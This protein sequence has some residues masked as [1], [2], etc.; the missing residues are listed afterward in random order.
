MPQTTTTDRPGGRRQKAPII[1]AAVLLLLVVAGFASGVGP[2][3]GMFGMIALVAGGWAVVRG[4]AGWL[5]L[6]T[7]RAGLV[8]SVA[9][10]AAFIVGM[11]VTAT[12]TPT[13]DASATGAAAKTSSAAPRTSSAAPRTSAAPVAIKAAPAT[14]AAPTTTSAS[15]RPPA[16][17]M[18]LTCPNGGSN[19]SPVF[20]QTISATAPYTVAI[21]YGD[22]DR[23]S[24]D[25]QHLGAV[26]SHTYKV[27]GNFTVEAT[28]TDAVGQA[29]SSSC[30]YNWVKL[31][32][33]PKTS[34]GT[35]GSVS[36]GGGSSS[37]TGS[38]T[39]GG[40]SSGGDTYTN[41]DGN[42]VHVPVQAPSAPAGATARCR[43]GSW[44][45]SQ[46]HSGTCSHHGGVAQWLG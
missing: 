4:R 38:A 34:G 5:H 12:P 39:D 46:N 23:Y 42:Q 6:A 37:G 13:N 45:F 29:V 44:S 27:S 2:G 22:G 18:Q 28:L 41:V 8:V 36:S 26:F 33:V 25:D 9:G 17:T 30:S 40:S 24:N 20:G 43:D 10:L 21:D 19:A 3:L 31:V 35:T 16:P 11:A 15:L 14:T 1:V 32:P 7:R